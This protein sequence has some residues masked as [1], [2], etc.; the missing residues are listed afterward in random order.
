MKHTVA[1]KKLLPAL[2]EFICQHWNNPA[3]LYSVKYDKTTSENK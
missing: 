3:M 1:R 2:V